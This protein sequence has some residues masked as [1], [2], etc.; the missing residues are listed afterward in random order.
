MDRKAANN[1]CVE[2][3]FGEKIKKFDLMGTKNGNYEGFVQRKR[4]LFSW[5][6]ETGKHEGYWKATVLVGLKGAFVGK[7]GDLA[8]TIYDIISRKKGRTLTHMARSGGKT[9]CGWNATSFKGVSGPKPKGQPRYA[10]RIYPLECVSFEKCECKNCKQ[11]FLAFARGLVEN[12]HVESLMEAIKQVQAIERL[13]EE[14]EC[15][16]S[17]EG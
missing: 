2:V 1:L 5:V 15:A 11:S 16:D 13:Q 17:G 14:M 4:V 9:W 8:E 6:E 10:E 12:G 7:G 3:E